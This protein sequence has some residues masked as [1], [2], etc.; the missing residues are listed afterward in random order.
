MTG[1]ELPPLGAPFAFSRP[2]DGSSII[3][4]TVLVPEQDYFYWP[5]ISGEKFPPAF[6]SAGGCIAGYSSSGLYPVAGLVATST[7]A[8]G[9]AKVTWPLLPAFRY[10]ASAFAGYTIRCRLVFTAP[11]GSFNGFK[12]FFNS[13]D[14]ILFQDSS[15]IQ[16]TFGNS[17]TWGSF[18]TGT[19]VCVFTF[20][21]DGTLTATLNGTTI[22]AGAGGGNATTIPPQ[23]RI[24]SVINN[25]GY[26]LVAQL[27]Q[28]QV[29][30]A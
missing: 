19:Y 14:Y 29:T 24:E 8:G 1:L 11:N 21:A 3:I 7:A 2:F 16:G 26:L 30:Y 10:S 6:V 13:T 20:A 23:V 27:A 15:Q 22:Y 18:F 4:P 5:C 17:A 9:P 25:G 12:L 28:L